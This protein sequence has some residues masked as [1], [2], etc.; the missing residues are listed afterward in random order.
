MTEA[1]WLACKD[2]QPM[3]EFLRGRASDRKLRIFGVACCL[4]I[5]SEKIGEANSR[6]AI[7]LAE[8]YV[9]GL[10]TE[11]EL[12][13]QR[14]GPP[15]FPYSTCVVQPDGPALLP[16]MIECAVYTGRVV[17]AGVGLR[18]RDEAQARAAYDQERCDQASLLRCVFGTLPFGCVTVAP[19]CL[20]WNSG[21]VVQLAQAIYFDRAF[22][23]LPILAD[24]LE[25][26]G[27][28]NQDI[29]AHCRQSGEHVRGCWVVD[30]LT[31]RE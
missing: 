14:S 6:R 4:R 5:Y 16:A 26:A 10:A 28:T 31:G 17:E 8:K 1:E 20:A 15:M 21:T 2:P 23:R 7:K 11:Q 19:S 24:A 13:A 27:C 29:L 3:L 12:R 25:D 9:E 22:D 30:L 18:T